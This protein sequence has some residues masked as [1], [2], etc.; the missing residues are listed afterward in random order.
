MVTCS[1]LQ[2]L[3]GGCAF[4]QL[5]FCSSI[6]VETNYFNNV[7]GLNNNRSF[8]GVTPALVAFVCYEIAPCINASTQR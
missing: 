1:S 2:R 5:N 4:G 3:H 6:F 7:I 8:I